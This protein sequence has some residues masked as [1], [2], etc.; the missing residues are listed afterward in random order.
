MVR[1]GNNMATCP[2]GNNLSAVSIVSD[3]TVMTTATAA[4]AYVSSDSRRRFRQTK[5]ASSDAQTMLT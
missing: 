1:H 4:A 2:A 3:A 5:R